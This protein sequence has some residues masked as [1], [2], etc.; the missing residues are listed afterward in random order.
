ME[1]PDA[2]ALP[3]LG[4]PGL[5]PADSDPDNNRDYILGGDGADTIYGGDDADTID[6]GLGSDLIDGGIDAGRNLRRFGERYY[7]RWR[8]IGYHYGRFRGRSGLW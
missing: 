6:G 4:Y 1:N 8:R 3:D 7:Y 2:S 5:Y